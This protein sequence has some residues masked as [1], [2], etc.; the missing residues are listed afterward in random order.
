MQFVAASCRRRG[1]EQLRWLLV[2]LLLPRRF[3]IPRSPSQLTMSAQLI[4]LGFTFIYLPI[5]SFF[6]VLAWF[7]KSCVQLLKYILC[8]GIRSAFLQESEH[9]LLPWFLGAHS[10]MCTGQIFRADFLFMH[11]LSQLPL[12]YPKIL[13]A[14]TDTWLQINTRRPEQIGTR[15]SFCPFGQTWF[16][17]SSCPK[18]GYT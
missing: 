14:L 13:G 17:P 2:G 16:P 18:Q 11:N 1:P 12:G 8:M 5:F 4:Q 15:H 7:I 6:S 10:I 3:Y 9:F